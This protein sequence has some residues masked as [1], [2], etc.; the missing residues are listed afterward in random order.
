M[1][2][3]AGGSAGALVALNDIQQEVLAQTQR[4]LEKLVAP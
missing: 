1:K 3:G 2:F 4:E